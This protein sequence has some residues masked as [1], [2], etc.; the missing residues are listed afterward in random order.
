MKARA[1]LLAAAL[2][3]LAAAAA[4][5]QKLEAGK[6]TGTI[7]PPGE[8]QTVEVTYDVTLKGD[9]LGMTINA[10]EHGS[11]PASEMKLAS[12]KLT[13]VFMPGPRVDCTLDRQNDGAYSGTCKDAQGGVATMVMIPPKK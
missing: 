12:G 5:A 8:Q 13:F 1:I 7:T 6:W 2:P 10:G 4:Q 9:S 11:F 3:F